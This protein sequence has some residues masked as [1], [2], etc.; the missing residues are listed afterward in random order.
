RWLSRFRAPNLRLTDAGPIMCDCQLRRDP[1]VRCSRFGRRLNVAVMLL[2]HKQNASRA[3]QDRSRLATHSQPPRSIGDREYE[4]AG[5]AAC[6][7][8]G[9]DQS[10]TPEPTRDDSALVARLESPSPAKRRHRATLLPK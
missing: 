5:A 10:Q 4:T 6:L 7:R 9:S 3:T 8:A 1:G 2:P